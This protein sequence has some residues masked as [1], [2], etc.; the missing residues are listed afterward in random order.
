MN[1]REK[2]ELY[3]RSYNENKEY[4]DTRIASGIEKNK[5][6]DCKLR[7]TSPSGNPIVGKK[8]TLTQK[9]HDFYHGA[10]I[11]MLDEFDSDELNKRYRE[12]FSRYFNLATVPFYW[13]TLEPEESKPRYA[14]DSPKIYRR[15]APDLCMEYCEQNGVMPKLHCLCYDYFSP[16]WLFNYSEEEMMEKYEKR[17]AE[18]AERYAGRMF[19]FEVLNEQFILRDGLTPLFFRKDFPKEIFKMARKY[20][21]NEKLTVNEGWQMESIA[22]RKFA[23]PYYLF[24]ENL[25]LSGTPIDRIGCQCHLFTGARAFTS[26]EYDK[27]VLEGVSHNDPLI[28]FKALDVLAELGLPIEITEVT[29]PTFGDTI[30]DEELQADMLKLWYS[31][32][33]SHPAVDT[34]VYW[35]T[36]DG[37]AYATPESRRDENHCRGGL[38]HKDMAPKL[39][40]LMQ[41]D[42]FDK[43]WHT[44]EVLETDAD[45]CITFRGFYG[46]YTAKY[47]DKEQTFAIHKNEKNEYTLSL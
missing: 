32:W 46:D 24:C 1:A 14:K 27:S 23:S 17:F 28:Y 13:N 43:V 6:G 41:K 9:T 44:D 26:E 22:S 38:F 12:T 8:I 33:F 45:G 29:V 5:K 3:M 37:Y 10:N 7:C 40:A 19:E 11:F 2:R 20:F 4:V 16:K 30:E 39:S 34:V 42:L 21:K 25:I 47:G 36:A 31:V 18:I 35:N 15:P